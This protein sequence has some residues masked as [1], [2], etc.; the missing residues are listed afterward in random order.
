MVC[1]PGVGFYGGLT[2]RPTMASA[3]AAL[4]CR[5]GFCCF[6]GKRTSFPSI[7]QSLKS[8]ATWSSSIKFYKCNCI[9]DHQPEDC[10]IEVCFCGP[11][12][13]MEQLATGQRQQSVS[14]Q[15]HTETENPS[16]RAT[17]NIIRRHFSDVS[18][19]LTPSHK[20]PYLLTV[21]RNVHSVRKFSDL[22]AVR[23][24]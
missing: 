22:T 1:V 8:V 13:C 16:P 9:W 15:F 20:C 6:M 12:S 4:T 5:H 18:M 10:R 11:T 21:S 2:V 19:I 24:H 3:F 23:S 14:E 7:A 17:T